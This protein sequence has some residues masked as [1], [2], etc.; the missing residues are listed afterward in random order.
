MS[1]CFSRRNL[2]IDD[3]KQLKR[4]NVDLRNQ[5]MQNSGQMIAIQME[6]NSLRSRESTLSQQNQLLHL[7]LQKM[8]QVISNLT[9]RSHR[10]KRSNR[11]AKVNTEVVT[12]ESED[13][14]WKEEE[15]ED[16]V[17]GSAKSTDLSP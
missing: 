4:E 8:Q 9:R 12:L 5:L 3:W 7:E 6:L 16:E 10:K 14:E 11:G 2:I 13:D 17:F 15:D 1:F